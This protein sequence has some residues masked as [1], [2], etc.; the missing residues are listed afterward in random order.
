MIAPII[1]FTIVFLCLFL[2][3]VYRYK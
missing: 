1:I 3:Y 2:L